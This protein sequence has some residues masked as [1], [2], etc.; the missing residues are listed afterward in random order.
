MIGE[1]SVLYIEATDYA[2]GLLPFMRKVA[3]DYAWAD[4]RLLP[5]M[6]GLATGYA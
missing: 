1:C 4:L 2:L 6:R 3:T 5:V